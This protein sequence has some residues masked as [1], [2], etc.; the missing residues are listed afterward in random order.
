MKKKETFIFEIRA[1]K[2]D[3][4]KPVLR[5]YPAKFNVMSED[6]GG[7]IENIAPGCFSEAIIDDDVRALFNHEAV[8]VLGRNRSGTLK[9]WED[10]IGLAMELYPPDTQLV[11][12]LVLTPIERGDITQMSFGFETVSDSWEWDKNPC[13]RT[14]LKARLYDVSPVTFPAY[15]QTEVALRSLEVA[16]QAAAGGSAPPPDSARFREILNL[17][18]MAAAVIL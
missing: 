9:L 3:D 17:Q 13:V 2:T 12:D 6:L 7:F 15:R 8:Y 18:A 16:K 5:G 10:D 11:R 1:A 4:G 14:L